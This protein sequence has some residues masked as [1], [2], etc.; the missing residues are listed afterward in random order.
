MSVIDRAARGVWDTNHSRQ[1]SASRVGSIFVVVPTMR[2]LSSA[3]VLGF[4]T[5]VSDGYVMEVT[6]HFYQCDRYNITD[7]GDTDN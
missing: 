3:A 1:V 2:V 6:K 7:V 4:V 5:T